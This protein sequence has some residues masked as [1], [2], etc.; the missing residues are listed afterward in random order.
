MSEERGIRKTRIGVVV[1]DKMDKTVVVAVKTKV[2]HPLYG[3][4]VNR[5]LKVGNTNIPFRT[6][7]YANFATN[8]MKMGKVDVTGLLTQYNG[9]W[10]L[11]VRTSRDI[12]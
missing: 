8:Y 12:Q 7:T 10:Q 11:T 2:R 6:S 9:E 1:S 4:M 3:K 5:T